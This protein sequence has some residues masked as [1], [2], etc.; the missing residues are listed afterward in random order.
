MDT[1]DINKNLPTISFG[2]APGFDGQPMVDFITITWPSGVTRTFKDASR[3]SNAERLYGE[4]MQHAE[5]MATRL[6]EVNDTGQVNMHLD[7]ACKVT[8][9]AFRDWELPF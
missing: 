6:Q 4:A 3:I 1:D 9:K 5:A 2:M 8:L 7:E